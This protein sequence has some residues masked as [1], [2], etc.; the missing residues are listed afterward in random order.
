MRIVRNNNAVWT[1]KHIDFVVNNVKSFGVIFSSQEE[2][3]QE[4][5][6]I[7]NGNP[8]QRCKSPNH[9]YELFIED[10]SYI[11]DITLTHKGNE[12]YEL[13]ILVFDKYA[14]NGKA[15]KAIQHFIDLYFN[16][17]IGRRIEATVLVTNPYRNKIRRILLENGFNYD[18]VNGSYYIEK[19]DHRYLN[20]NNMNG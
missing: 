9:C 7:E 12:T 19:S 4:L 8:S 5:Q 1:K 6:R 11:G 20:K 15:K 16:E 13:G 18:H 10:G 17:G 2:I 14:G 3:E